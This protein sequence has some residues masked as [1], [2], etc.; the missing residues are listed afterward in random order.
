MNSSVTPADVEAIAA[1]RP[2]YSSVAIV[3]HWLIAALIVANIALAWYFT[4]LS[5]VAAIRPTQWH[6]S[7]GISVLLLSLARLAWRF[8]RPP[9]PP[10][11][12]LEGWERVASATVFVL[13]Y[14]VM[15]GLP[16]TGWAMVSASRLIRVFP[17]KLFYLNWPAIEPLANLAP[18]P[19]HQAH[20]LF[21]QVHE[22]L[23]WLLYA[24]LVLHVGAAIRHHFLLRDEVA[25]RMLPFL[26]SR[27]P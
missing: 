25:P 9:P 6:K 23:G 20:E 13:F 22:K 11:A 21:L 10:P 7:I 8:I 16:L 15:I 5:G 17:I 19:Q 26:K 1:V 24:L 18:G 27:R 2:S 3:L 12:T 14:A 4:N